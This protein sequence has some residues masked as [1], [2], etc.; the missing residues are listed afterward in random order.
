MLDKSFRPGEVESRLYQMWEDAGAFRPA[1]K[2]GAG[3]FAI[4]IQPPN[5]TGSLHI[6]HALNNLG[7]H[8]V[9]EVRQGKV[10]DL[11]LA[12]SNRERAEEVIRNMCEQLLA[13]TVIEKYDIELKP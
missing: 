5:V 4:V 6:G 11:E 3:N 7:F 10:I 1:Q 8:S 2:P 9:G 13:N 12:E